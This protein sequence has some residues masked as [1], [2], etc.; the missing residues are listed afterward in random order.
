M[1]SRSRSRYLG[2]VS[3]GKLSTS[4]WAAQAAGG[5]SVT[6]TWTS[7]RRS[8]RR[9]RNPK[10]VEGEGRDDEEVDGDNLADMCSEEG[11][12]RRGW[13]WRGAPHVLGHGEL[14]DLIAEEPQFGLDPTPAP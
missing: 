11:A 3:S 12:P 1:A 2:V 9:I 13:S 6:L 10:S 14:G 4:W 5:W 7:S 8:C